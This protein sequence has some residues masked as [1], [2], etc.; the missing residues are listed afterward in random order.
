MFGDRKEVGREVWT[1]AYSANDVLLAARRRRTHCEK[2]LKHWQREIGKREKALSAKG[3]KIER[4]PNPNS[5]MYGKGV[6]VDE[7]MVG[8]V[9]EAVRMANS[10]EQKVLVYC[11]WITLLD[12]EEG[13]RTL[14]LTMEDAIFFGF[15][16]A[17]TA[18]QE[19]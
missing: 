14:R 18:A 16:M 17:T 1:F 10:Y 13:T 11:Q 15:V 7:G 19:D 8:Q 4:R 9:H 3:V 5:S 2:R 6:D 12:R